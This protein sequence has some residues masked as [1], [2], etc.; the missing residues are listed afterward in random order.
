MV[1]EKDGDLRT[2]RVR[3]EDV[4]H[5]VKGERNILHKVKKRRF[6]WIGHILHR[7]CLLMQIIEDMLGEDEE[8][9]VNSYWLIVGKQEYTVK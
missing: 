2:D 5:R 6:N 9:D 4:L 3:N 7:N 1:L 8:E